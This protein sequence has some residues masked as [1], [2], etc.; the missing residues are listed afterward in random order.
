MTADE[1][2][3]HRKAPRRSGKEMRHP[4]DRRQEGGEDWAYYEKRTCRQRRSG[5][6]R[7]HLERRHPPGK[8]E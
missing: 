3:E 7:R 1:T 8:S 4:E 6:D 2:D 5:D